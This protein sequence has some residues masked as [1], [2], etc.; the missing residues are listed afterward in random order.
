M[1]GIQR[2]PD[3]LAIQI[4]QWKVKINNVFLNEG[5]LLFIVGY[6]EQILSFDTSNRETVVRI[7]FTKILTLNI[8]TSSK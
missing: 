5:I 3:P 6:Q 2:D 8:L 1:P 7:I 4:K